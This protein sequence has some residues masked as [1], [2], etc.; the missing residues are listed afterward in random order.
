MSS[1]NRSYPLVV[2]GAGAAGLV[3]AIGA[4]KAGRKV[5]LVENRH[6][7]GDCT[8]YGCI[9]S[10]SLISAAE[11][12][13]SVRHADKHGIQVTNNTFNAD[14]ALQYARDVVQSIREH[15]EPPELAKYGVDCL[16][17]TASFVSASELKIMMNNG[18]RVNV[19]ADKI[20]IATGSHPYIPPIEGLDEVNYHTNETIFNLEKIP[21]RLA[22]LGAG[23]IGIELA[24]AMSRLGSKVTIIERFDT[25]FFRHEP[26]VRELMAACLK[27][28]GID[29]RLNTETL[30][31][32]RHLDEV[33]LHCHDHNHDEELVFHADELLVSVGR[34][35]NLAK[36]N[37]AAAGVE[38]TEFGLD[39]DAYGRTNVPHIWA[40]GDVRGGAMFTHIAEN[41]ARSVL[42]NL[43]S[44]WTLF[45]TSTQALSTVTYV[46]PEVAT[47]GLTEQ[48]AVDQYGHSRLAVYF[49]DFKQLDR[50]LCAGDTRGFVKVITK[51]WSSRILGAT[52]VGARAGEMICELA[53]AM[54]Y[55]ISL[56]KLAKLI[57]PYPVYSL[58]I[59]KAADLWLTQTIINSLKAPW[60]A[61]RGQKKA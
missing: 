45:K 27:E 9:P 43:L 15:E 8:N 26:E 58:A 34:R 29:L 18:S 1:I 61:R 38:H 59:R 17:G 24:Q 51:K 25:L 20:V 53:L 56:R 57:H 28:E 47:L 5:L 48:E 14:N 13:Q 36:L 30:E 46:A 6:Y 10:K 33:V 60:K 11:I 12:A 54:Q 7:G 40:V 21:N 4:A 19:K 49:I 39:V 22:I 31:I 41:Q 23:P 37:L 35:P 44:P 32:T 3:I 2:I 55:K 52:I 42:A 16:T 50:A